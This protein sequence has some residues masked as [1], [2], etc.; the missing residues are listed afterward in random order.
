MRR[1]KCTGTWNYEPLS[2]KISSWDSCPGSKCTIKLMEFGIYPVI[3]YGCFTHVENVFHQYSIFYH[4][5]SRVSLT[6]YM[7]LGRIT[8]CS[9][10]HDMWCVTFDWTLCKQGWYRVISGT[11]S[12]MLPKLI[13]IYIIWFP[14]HFDPFHPWNKERE[15]HVY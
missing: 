10:A 4:E 13:P 6:T 11:G 14:R 15:D 3:R 9:W 2:F 8:A 7:L 1:L 5:F 12:A